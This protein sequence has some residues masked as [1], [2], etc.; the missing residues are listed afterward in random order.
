[1]MLG[2]DEPAVPPLPSPP[3]DDV[4]ASGDHHDHRL[5]PDYPGEKQRLEWK[6]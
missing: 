2:K 4:E 3:R 1:M 6:R 5:A